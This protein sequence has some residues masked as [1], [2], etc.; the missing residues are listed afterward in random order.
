[1]SVETERLREPVPP[2]AI[3]AM[4]DRFDLQERLAV[5]REALLVA[6]PAMYAAE[7]EDFDGDIGAVEALIETLEFDLGVE[8]REQS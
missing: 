1:M 5:V 3:R 8:V 6:I 7:F 2:A 4:F